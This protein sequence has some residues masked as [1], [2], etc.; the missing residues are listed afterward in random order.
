M[1]NHDIE[2][3]LRLLQDVQRILKHHAAEF[4]EREGVPWT[5]VVILRHVGDT[6]GITVTELGRRCGLS[7]G[8]VSVLLDQMEVD[9]WIHKS[10]DP[11]DQRRKRLR[12]SDA[13]VSF[14]S[15]LERKHLEF[16][17]QRLQAISPSHLDAIIVGLQHLRD[18]FGDRTHQNNKGKQ[19]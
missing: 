6:P 2:V 13:G 4:L 5:T 8:Y 18:A 10:P 9:G 1:K 15:S 17:H 16:L 3:M 7:K 19:G 12:L 11:N 14:R